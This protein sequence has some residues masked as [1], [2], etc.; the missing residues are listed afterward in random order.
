[1]DSLCLREPGYYHREYANDVEQKANESDSIHQCKRVALVALPFLSLYKPLGF[2]LSLGMGALRS[3]TSITNLY[4]TFAN[5]G[6]REEIANQFLQTTVSV[7]AI[8]GT[9]FAHPLGMVIATGHDIV[10]EVISFADHI[11]KGE[12]GTAI[13]N[14]ANILNNSL[15]LC[16]F[17]SGG[18]ELAIASLGMQVILGLYHSRKE[19]IKGN[20]LEASGHL[21]MALIRG[22]Q[23][24]GQVHTLQLKWEAQKKLEEQKEAEF[25]RMAATIE[26]L[27][28]IVSEQ[29]AKLE[30]LQQNTAT[31]LNS[32][33]ELLELQ[34]TQLMDLEKK[35]SDV[36][37]LQ[38]ILVSYG[39][40]REGLPAF[41]Y[42]IKIGDEKTVNLFL[43][44]GASLDAN[45][46]AWALH[47]AVMSNQVDVLRVLLDNGANMDAYFDISNADKHHLLPMHPIREAAKTGSAE[48]ID[49]LIERGADVNESRNFY[50]D[51]WTKK[52]TV[53]KNLVETPLHIA[54]EAG[55]F[56]AIIALVNHGAD[57]NKGETPGRNMGAKTPLDLAV[58]KLTYTDNPR[59]LDL[60]K[61]L[62]EHGARRNFVEYSQHNHMNGQVTTVLPCSIIEGYLKSKNL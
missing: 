51:S 53:C 1:M 50:G 41:H 4:A 17:I 8:A 33:T 30:M 18:L 2:T 16:M 31:E 60:V 27:Q 59:N 10:L 40:N 19:F 62:V 12:Y 58:K 9:L 7:V 46:S 5:G 3:V 44:H 54:A 26:H 57:I 56:D 36:Q 55:N 23:L 49:F 11:Q 14:T 15:Y 45:A 29:T 52:Y 24:L 39:N 34:K 42:A 61:F 21:A 13:E 25:K 47:Y 32:K 22:N 37:H 28:K 20:Y 48:L 35:L 43:Q 6:S 38:D